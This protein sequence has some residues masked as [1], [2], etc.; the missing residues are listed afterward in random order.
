MKTRMF[1]TAMAMTMACGL[2]ACE[3]ADS[4]AE[5]SS[6]TENSSMT[7]WTKLEVVQVETDRIVYYTLDELQQASDLI[8]IGEFIDDAEQDVEYQYND[9]F[10]K[11]SVTDAVSTNEIAV[12]RV[13]K[14]TV[15]EDGVR[16]SQ[17]YGILEEE[18]QL[19]TF[20]G[21]T[22]MKKGEQ[23]IFFLYYGEGSDSYWCAGDYTG[24]Y[25]LPQAT[26][27][28]AN[29]EQNPEVFGLYREE[30][31][32]YPLYQAILNEYEII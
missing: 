26:A 21:M 11:K 2:T 3:S 19:V 28:A 22:P 31:I 5:Q 10:K 1:A 17:R 18:N 23:W 32:N 9:D 14:G 29:A 12:H 20:S 4:S 8:V 25:P 24:R 7:D 15:P 27:A 13:L 6:V 30:Q 16:I